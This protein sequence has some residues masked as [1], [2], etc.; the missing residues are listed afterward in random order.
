MRYAT[1][2]MKAKKAAMP[3]IWSL[4]TGALS[5]VLALADFTCMLDLG[6]MAFDS[7]GLLGMFLA[8]SVSAGT[9]A[10]PLFAGKLLRAYVDGGEED[11]AARRACLVLSVV[12]VLGFVALVA[13]VYWFRLCI[14]G[15]NDKLS[16][17]AA[18]SAVFG[19]SSATTA[20]GQA[21]PKAVLLLVLMV[22][23]GI[24]SFGRAYA[25]VKGSARAVATVDALRDGHVMWELAGEQAA[26]EVMHEEQELMDREREAVDN[27]T[28]ATIALARDLLALETVIDPVQAETIVRLLNE[29][30][31]ASDVAHKPAELIEWKEES[32]VHEA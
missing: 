20:E 23:T 17:A 12:L 9:I 31:S 21:L 4:V 30:T 24:V 15:Q 14:E 28:D 16:F 13:G 27:V 5:V 26:N 1:V 32:Y 3:P 7:D 18:G 19:A 2:Y 22:V 10:V 8:L 6:N 11:A 25:N 29:L